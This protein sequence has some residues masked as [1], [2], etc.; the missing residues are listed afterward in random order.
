MEQPLD[1]SWG[2]L[3]AVACCPYTADSTLS[4]LVD[5]L[6]EN[7]KGAYLTKLVTR[8]IKASP[9]TKSKAMQYYRDKEII[10]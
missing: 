4:S 8:N 1:R 3:M 7:E 10:I 9:E 2:A 6:Y 5:W